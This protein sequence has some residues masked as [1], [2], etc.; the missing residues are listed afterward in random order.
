[1]KK[2]NNNY[3]E[4]SFY[5]CQL[6]N[7]LDLYVIEKPD[8]NTTCCLFG[9]SFG[10]LN[11]KQKINGEII[12]YPT[13]IAHFLE[14][15]LFENEDIDV[16]DKFS[17]LDANVNAFTSY[18]E[19]V[20]YFSTITKNIKPSLELLLDFVQK[21]NI[22]ESG[23]EKEKNIIIQEVL[24]YHN[25]PSHRMFNETLNNLYH[26]N[27][28]KYDIGGTIE[29]IKSITIDQLTKCHEINYHP[30]NMK[31]VVISPFKHQIIYD[32]V[33][34]NQSK[35][36]FADVEI[37]NIF[38]KEPIESVINFKEIE[39]PV[40]KNKCCYGIKLNIK[41][42][43]HGFLKLEQAFK[44]AFEMIFSNLNPEYQNWL[45]KGYINDFFEF[46]I[47]INNNNQ[48]LFFFNETDDER[49]FKKFIDDNILNFIFDENKM[50]KLKRRY[51]GNL[52]DIFN[53]IENYG[54]EFTRC[55]LENVSLFELVEILNNVKI[56]DLY[57]AM[58]LISLE[59]YTLTKIVGK[60]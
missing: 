44:L 26:N 1:M 52:F 57:E 45:D 60:E 22:S 51:L 7:G 39:M 33:S 27:P 32:I 42:D 34:Q 59:N 11:L 55:I 43:S 41:Q 48:T 13:G 36:Y 54:Y 35:K 28:I 53:Y 8:F 29:D 16:M 50:I 58:K 47:D 6:E 5:Y 31:L 37:E 38:E 17:D 10:S 49:E 3:L 9:T 15:K 40:S 23:V 4:E 25:N 30:K 21:L 19:T 18:R 56:E 2:I 20:Y 24:M 12:N 46:E 14:H